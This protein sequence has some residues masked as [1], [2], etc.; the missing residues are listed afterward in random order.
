M[1]ALRLLREGG[2]QQIYRLILAE[3]PGC[4]GLHIGLHPADIVLRLL[5]LAGGKQAADHVQVV[6]HIVL[7]YRCLRLG[8]PDGVHFLLG[9][10]QLY[11]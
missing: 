6:A 3:A 5:G 4:D 8:L 9:L 11:L 10:L 2:A 1:G 7:I